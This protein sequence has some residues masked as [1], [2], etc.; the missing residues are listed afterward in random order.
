[1]TAR[2]RILDAAARVMRDS[3]LARTTTKEI[4]RAAGCSEALLYKY[5]ADKQ[6]I[7]L[8]VLSERM[9]ALDAPS[10]LAGTA[11]VPANLARLTAGLLRFYVRSFPMAAS[12]FGTPELLASWRAGMAARGAG[13]QLPAQLLE[14]YLIAEIDLGRVRPGLDVTGVAALLCGAAMQQ[15]FLACFAGLDEV[16]DTDAL[17]ERLV[18]QLD[19]AAHPALINGPSAS[20]TPRARDFSDRD[21]AIGLPS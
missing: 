21:S 15:A 3:G 6:E 8:G 10:A 13:P 19:L 4:A 2:D 9:P 18:A 20:S 11:T 16:P 14:H 7:F 17:A 5:F 1:M 12:I